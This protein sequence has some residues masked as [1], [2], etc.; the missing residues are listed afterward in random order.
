[1]ASRKREST[2]FHR[3]KRLIPRDAR[4]RFIGLDP[5]E[6]GFARDLRVVRAAV[7][8][9]EDLDEFDDD[10]EDQDEQ[11]ERTLH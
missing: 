3:V 8:E 11:P 2:T 10:D 4:G 9:D 7:D 6:G 1:M 5:L